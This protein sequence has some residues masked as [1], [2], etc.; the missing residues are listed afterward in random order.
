MSLKD[1]TKHQLMVE[2]HS[3][4]KELR[5]FTGPTHAQLMALSKKCLDLQN[6]LEQFSSICA[7]KTLTNK[8]LVKIIYKLQE[9]LEERLGE[10]NQEWKS[11]PN[12]NSNHMA[13]MLLGEI[14]GLKWVFELIT[15]EEFEF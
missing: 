8:R 1:K 10:L 15:G 9:H 11:E 14:D 13:S 4:H 5:D 3:L 2:I 6:R 7:A 12:K